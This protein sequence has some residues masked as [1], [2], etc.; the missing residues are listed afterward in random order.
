MTSSGVTQ[1]WRM[2]LVVLAAVGATACSTFT[3]H[4]EGPAGP[5][6]PWIANLQFNPH[7]VGVG[8]NTLMSF[9]FQV[10]SADLREGYLIERGISQ[11]Q[12]YQA[13]QTIPLDLRDYNGQVAGV[14]ELP[15]HWSVEGI[16]QLELYVV[17]KQGNASNR[18]RAT[19]TVH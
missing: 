3:A 5:A 4:P 11:F 2:L 9:Y 12:F 14:V 13:L 10:G 17:T 8:Q 16:R 15:L 19:I 7:V 18:I 6:T 1:R